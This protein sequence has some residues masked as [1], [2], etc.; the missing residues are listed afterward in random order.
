MD[1]KR[2]FRRLI[3]A[4]FGTWAFTWLVIGASAAHWID[5][6]S[7]EFNAASRRND[8]IMMN[9]INENAHSASNWLQKSI[10]VGGGGLFVGAIVLAIGFWVYRGFYPKDDMR[11]AS[12]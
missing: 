7:S 9:I 11:N 8:V 6:W 2:G 3:I 10:F 4:I 5:Y 12:K 1:R